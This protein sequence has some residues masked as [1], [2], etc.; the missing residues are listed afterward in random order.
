MLKMVVACI[1]ICTILVCGCQSGNGKNLQ[2]NT[3]N[4]HLYPAQT[5]PD[6]LD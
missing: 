2:N 6:Y 4:I 3:I 5:F 1:L